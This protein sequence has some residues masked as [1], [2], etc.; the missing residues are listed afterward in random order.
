VVWKLEMSGKQ[1]WKRDKGRRNC[2]FWFFYLFFIW[3][4]LHFCRW[5]FHMHACLPSLHIVCE[6]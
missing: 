5:F 6:K 1:T 2:F 3:F 4:T